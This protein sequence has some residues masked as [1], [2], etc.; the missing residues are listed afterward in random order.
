[1][2][3]PPQCGHQRP[4]CEI[5]T[6]IFLYKFTPLIRHSKQMYI[7]RY[8]MSLALKNGHFMFLKFSYV[9]LAMQSIHIRCLRRILGITW[10]DRVTNTAVLEKTGSLSMHLM[11]CQRRLRWLGH[12]HRMDDGRIPKDVMYGELASGRRPTGRPA[13]RFKDVCKRDLKLT[14]IDPD[15]W[16]SLADDRS[17]WSH[18]VREGVRRGEEKRNQQ[19][20]ERRTRRKERQQNQTPNPPSNFVCGNCGRD[21]HFG[22]DCHGRIGLLSHSRRCS[23]RD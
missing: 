6:C 5:P 15:T 13:L 19:L 20:E 4:H 7:L 22:R 1:M 3:P 9:Y 11:L 17:G 10:Q 23:Q 14:G 18:A 2:R 8:F 16:E 21:C 12:V